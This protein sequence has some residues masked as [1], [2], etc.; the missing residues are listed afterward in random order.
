[1]KKIITILAFA[2]LSCT[3]DLHIHYTEL[4]DQ[5]RFAWTQQS[6][7]LKKAQLGDL[8]PMQSFDASVFKFKGFPLPPQ[9]IIRFFI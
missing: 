6:L 1:M 3:S 7:A 8:K 5:S 4:Q 2:F 9:I